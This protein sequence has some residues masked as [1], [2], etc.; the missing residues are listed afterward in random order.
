MYCGR[1][2]G[3]C[4]RRLS[5]YILWHAVRRAEGRT[6]YRERRVP[7]HLAGIWEQRFFHLDVYTFWVAG[8]LNFYILINDHET[9]TENLFWEVD[10]MQ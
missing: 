3:D 6:C 1:A 4:I 5:E 7:S 9:F 2:S 10:L 8:S